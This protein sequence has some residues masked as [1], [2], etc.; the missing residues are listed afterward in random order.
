MSN[1]LQA[2]FLSAAALFHRTHPPGS[3]NLRVSAGWKFP[4]PKTAYLPLSHKGAAQIPPAMCFG[5]SKT[6]RLLVLLNLI[7]L[8][9]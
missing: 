3:V 4:L 8:P 5:F 1:F 7:S 2:H 9:G 6:S